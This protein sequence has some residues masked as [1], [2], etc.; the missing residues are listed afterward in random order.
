MSRLLI[1]NYLCN[2]N[3]ILQDWLLAQVLQVYNRFL[4]EWFWLSYGPWKKMCFF[5]GILQKYNVQL[6]HLG[7]SHFLHI[8]EVTEASIV[9]VKLH[10]SVIYVCL[11]VRSSIRLSVWL[12]QILPWLQ[13]C[14]SH[15]WLVWFH[16]NFTGMIS[17]KSSCAYHQ[18]FTVDWFLS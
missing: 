11:F 1:L 10:F 7:N 17:I 15:K 16:S 6:Y 12:S 4:I 5:C 3:E 8:T 13:K 14:T 18:H 9:T 2:L